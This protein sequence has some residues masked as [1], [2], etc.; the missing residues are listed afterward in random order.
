[1]GIS[2]RMLARHFK[3]ETS[4]SFGHWRQH[5]RAAEAMTWLALGRVATQVALD[6]GYSTLGAFPAMF[7]RLFGES[8]QQSMASSSE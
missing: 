5:M 3:E 6:P 7:R 4:M 1:M 8:P 2:G